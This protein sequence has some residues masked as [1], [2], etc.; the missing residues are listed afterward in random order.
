MFNSKPIS[1]EARAVITGAGS[2]IG[3]AF[4]LE[5][6][7]RGGEVLCADINL[8]SAKATAADI[9]K[10]GGSAWAT[11]CDVTDL[12][13]VEALAQTAQD[14]FGQPANLII[15]NAGIGTGG[16]P[17]GETSMDDWKA[18]LDINLWGVIYGCHVFTPQLRLAGRGGIINVGSTASFAA[19]PLMGPYNVSKAGV[20]AL[21]ETLAAELAGTRVNVCALCPTFV[22]T[23]I[24][25]DGRIS[26]EQSKLASRV[27]AWTGV[28]ADGV[29]LTALKALDRGQLYVMPQLDARTVWRMKRYAPAG[30]LQGT[31]LVSRLMSR[32]AKTA[33]KGEPDAA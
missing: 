22:K 13:A 31:R 10:A 28:S 29:V 26:G 4:S 11:T 6:A 5:L 27:M 17:I 12:A 23:N 20:L 19:A 2:G 7:R 24:V 15:N 18:T 32:N 33:G 30:Y 8:T 14:R 25:K 16:R 3:R 9:R 1:R 21:S